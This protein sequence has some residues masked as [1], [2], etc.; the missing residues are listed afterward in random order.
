MNHF[1]RN[2][3]KSDYG[4]DK[5]NRSDRQYKTSHPH[6]EKPTGLN[7][8]LIDLPTVDRNVIKNHE[9]LSCLADRRTHR[10]YLDKSL[11]LM[12]LSFLLWA[13]QG[14]TKTY[15][16]YV[17]RTVPSGGKAHAFETYL[18]IN[19]VESLNKGVYRYLSLSHQLLYLTDVDRNFE[20]FEKAI[21]KQGF[22]KNS[23]VIF[24]WSCIPER[25]EWR[26]G[27]VS[28]HK[29]ML[30]DA[31]HVG[32]NLYI[33]CEAIGCGTCAI[34]AY[35]QKAIDEFLGLDGEDEFIIY[36]APVGKV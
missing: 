10:K 22:I 33:A 34:A 9:L 26:S 2:F 4:L 18:I 17:L 31:G 36:M 19:N 6:L 1:G 11:S 3:M 23:P 14:V 8:I 21:A 32:Q 16:S 5:L 13:T 27:I 20:K 28:R 30:L 7:P 12:E 35:D 25:S 24:I 29:S 15:D